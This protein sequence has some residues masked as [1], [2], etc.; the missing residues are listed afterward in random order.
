MSTSTRI[1]PE[2][3]TP[4]QWSL[5]C[6]MQRHRGGV[7]Q[8]EDLLRR[9]ESDWDDLVDLRD[10]ELVVFN[11]HIPTRNPVQRARLDMGLTADG[12]NLA[13]VHLIPL[14]DVL[15]HVRYAGNR[16]ATI[17]DIVR[18]V[19]AGWLLRPLFVGS[20]PMLEFRNRDGETVRRPGWEEACTLGGGSNWPG[21]HVH[22]TPTGHRFQ[23]IP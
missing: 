10:R 21:L 14:G 23:A 1:S 9:T 22:L 18:L 19:A 7:Y 6:R 11:E 17:P 15:T 2:Q 13:E 20:M 16:G 8:T 12:R 3:L 5:L 4:G